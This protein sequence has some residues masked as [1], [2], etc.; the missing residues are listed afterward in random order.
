MHDFPD[1]PRHECF[2]V[3]K[4]GMAFG[5]VE[6]WQKHWQSSIDASFIREERICQFLARTISASYQD[7]SNQQVP[8]AIASHSISLYADDPDSMQAY[9]PSN[10]ETY[11]SQRRRNQAS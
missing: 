11:S 4:T 6:Q 2:I 1:F 8:T 7:D 10:V 5:Q 3:S 9:L